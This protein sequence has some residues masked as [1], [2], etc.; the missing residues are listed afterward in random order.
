[1]ASEGKEQVCRDETSL[2]INADDW[3]RDAETTDRILDC[4]TMS[5]VS[6]T[7]AMVFMEDSARAAELA[8]EHDVDCGLHLN[9]TTQF[10]AADCP[11]RL[12]EHQASVIRYLRA[13]RLAQVVYHP[14][15][16]SSFRYVVMSQIEESERLYG[17][18]PRRVDGHHHMHLCANVLVAKLMPEGTIA[19]RNFSF[20]P[21]EKGRINRIYR[22]AIDGILAR[23]HRLT[24]YFFSLPPL[25]PQSRVREI[26]GTARGAVI[27]VETHPINPEEYKFLTGGEVL[28]A[29][30]DIR[31]SQGF[32]DPVQA[33]AVLATQGS[34]RESI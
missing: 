25:Q 3:G 5:T 33:R 18:K 32:T 6:S 8:R 31:I 9:L 26:F 17:C 13:N 14:G 27:E 12:K 22:S 29:A 15:L 23:R 28:R 34:S 1:M 11:Q 19:R 2:I 4:V 10:S 21:G 16:A 30:G 20:G 24:D 7:S